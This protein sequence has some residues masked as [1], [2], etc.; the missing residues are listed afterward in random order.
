LGDK[1]GVEITIVPGGTVA[2]Q[3]IK[4]KRPKCVIAVACHRDLT[5]G[6][7]DVAAL[8][9]YGVVNERPF[10]P[11]INTSV[12][13]DKVEEALKNVFAKISHRQISHRLDQLTN[14]MSE[15]LCKDLSTN[16][17]HEIGLGRLCLPLS[18]Y[19]KC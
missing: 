5:S 14:E 1:Y 8:P 12:D 6:V 7:R 9:V 10:G 11:C 2:R 13:A 18:D 3:I 15:L 19:F 17:C 4:Q 16:P